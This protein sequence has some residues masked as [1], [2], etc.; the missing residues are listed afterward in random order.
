[1]NGSPSPPLAVPDSH[2]TYC[3]DVAALSGYGFPLFE[4]PLGLMKATRPTP[5]EGD[6]AQLLEAGFGTFMFASERTLHG[7]SSTFHFRGT[8]N[9]WV[10][11]LTQ[12]LR[13]HVFDWVHLI[14]SPT[15]LFPDANYLTLDQ[16]WMTQLQPIP[17]PTPDEQAGDIM[18]VFYTTSSQGFSGLPTPDSSLPPSPDSTY[19]SEDAEFNEVMSSFLDEGEA[20]QFSP[21]QLG[22]PVTPLSYSSYPQQYDSELPIAPVGNNPGSIRDMLKVE[23]ES[24]PPSSLAFSDEKPRPKRRLTQS[25][26]KERK[27]QQNKS[28][29]LRYRQ[30]KKGEKEESQVKLQDLELKNSELKEKVKSLHN[31]IDYLKQ[32][33]LEVRKAKRRKQ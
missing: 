8:T 3:S 10:H 4:E 31:E 22:T 16:D 9:N 26:R 15:E 23:P 13:K 20:P 7:D 1:M 18:S 25:A 30:R 28:A 14:L 24:P 5:L 29:A 32:L 17:L 33:W 21:N 19:F 6:T 27:K 12:Y 2:S 11:Y